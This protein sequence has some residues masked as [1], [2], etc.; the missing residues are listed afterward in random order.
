MSASLTESLEL[1]AYHWNEI[2]AIVARTASIVITTISST[3]VKALF[4]IFL[5]I[6][7]R[8]INNI[9]YNKRKYYY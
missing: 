7:R 2:K 1:A 8:I 9:I 3:S 4:F 5:F 6:Y